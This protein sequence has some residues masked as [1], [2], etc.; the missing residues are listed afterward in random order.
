MV[1]EL[2]PVVDLAAP[3]APQRIDDACRRIGFLS[4]VNHGVS[5]AV[6]ARMCAAADAF[7]ALPLAA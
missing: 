7:F 3:G 5:D 2:V 4:V 1:A 6:I